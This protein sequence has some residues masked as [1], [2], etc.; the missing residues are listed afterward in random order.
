MHQQSHV[1]G[2][3]C[4]LRVEVLPGAFVSI[5]GSSMYSL[6]DFVQTWLPE[7]PPPTWRLCWRGLS[8][9]VSPGKLRSRLRA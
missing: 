5:R 1:K 6:V 9:S 3:P 7:P 8:G 2:A 4:V